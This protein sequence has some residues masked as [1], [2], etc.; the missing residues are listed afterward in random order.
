VPVIANEMTMK[1]D[2]V[3]YRIKRN[4]SFVAVMS[5]PC[6]CCR[7]QTATAVM[8]IRDATNPDGLCSFD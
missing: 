5:V 7:A 1:L 6:V 2:A 3:P 4:Q 8:D